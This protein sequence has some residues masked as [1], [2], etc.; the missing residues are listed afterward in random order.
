MSIQ[1]VTQQLK[2]EVGDAVQVQK[3][4]MQYGRNEQGE[5]V[6]LYSFR[7]SKNG[8]A[9]TTIEI[10]CRDYSNIPATVMQAAERAKTWAAANE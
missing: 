9:T 1:D 6:E 8:G 7:V 3:V 10:E 4:T 5:Q 2:D